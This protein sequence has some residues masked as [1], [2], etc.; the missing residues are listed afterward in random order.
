VKIADALGVSVEYLVTGKDARLSQRSYGIVR[1]FEQLTETDRK[2]AFD[3]IQW[4]K[5]REIV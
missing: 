1:L 5:N 2:F 3:F 4:L